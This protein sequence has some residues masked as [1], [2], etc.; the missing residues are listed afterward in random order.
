[1]QKSFDVPFPTATLFL[2]DTATSHCR[3]LL[4]DTR[5]VTSLALPKNNTETQPPPA[6]AIL[7]ELLRKDTD[8]SAMLEVIV[9]PTIVRFG[10][11]KA[12]IAPPHDEHGCAASPAHPLAPPMAELRSKALLCTSRYKPL[13]GP[14]TDIAPPL[15]AL[16]FT[17]LQN[18]TT[19]LLPRA[20][21]APPSE[22]GLT[23]P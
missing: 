2:P 4:F 16:Q 3:N 8:A 17:K 9:H 22:L 12:A 11:S 18:D 1:V 14:V 10:I 13:P 20:L 6:T 21:K 23:Q 5:T 7:D 15:A 19:M